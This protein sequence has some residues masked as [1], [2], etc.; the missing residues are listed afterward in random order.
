MSS[1]PLDLYRSFRSKEI[2][3]KMRPAYS[4]KQTVRASG[5]KGCDVSENVD[6]YNVLVQNCDENDLWLSPACRNSVSMCP[7]FLISN[8]VYSNRVVLSQIK[9]FLNFPYIQEF[10]IGSA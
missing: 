1:K 5:K 6:A 2:L 8:V 10:S 9:N 4:T 3:A 7:E